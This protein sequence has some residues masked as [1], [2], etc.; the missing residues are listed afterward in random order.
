MKYLLI[1]VLLITVNCEGQKSNK[2]NNKDFVQIVKSDLKESDLETFELVEFGKI[3]NESAP[4]GDF[5]SRMWT[6]FGKPESVMFEGF[7]Y[8][9]KDT[10]T[11]VIFSVY[12]GASGPGYAAKKN[13]IEKVKPRIYELEKILDNSKNS[14]CEEEI[15]TDFGTYLCGAKNGIPYD[16]EK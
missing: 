16:K 2:M 5:L 14:D 8:F 15:E 1:L 10:K 7:N 9:I 3:R 12:F 11:N 4:M 6:N 13:D